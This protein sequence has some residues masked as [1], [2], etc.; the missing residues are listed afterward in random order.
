MAEKQLYVALEIADHEIRL[1]VGEFFNTRFNILKIE[2]V[3]TTGILGQ[4]IVKKEAVIENIKKAVANASKQIGASIE[5]VLLCIPSVNSQRI[6]KRVSVE[7]DKRVSVNDISRAV[8]TASQIRPK[9]GL[10]LIN[11]A[12][13]KY[14]CNGITT[15]RMPLNEECDELIVDVDLL[16]ADRTVTFDYVSCVEKA[17]LSILDICLDSYAIAKEA[18]LFEQAL[19][20][21]TILV[22][23]QE[24]STTLSYFADGRLASSI[25][26]NTGL[27]DFI[28]SLLEKTA[29]KREEA[30]KL[31]KYNTRL[32]LTNFETTPVYIWAAGGKTKTLSEKELYETIFPKAKEWVEEIGSLCGPILERD[33]VK[34]VLCGDGGE[35]QGIDALMKEILHMDV[36]IYYPETVGGRDSSL[37]T[38]LGAFYAYKDQ[39]TILSSNLSSIN[40]QEFE[41][42]INIKRPEK[43]T[44]DTITKKLKG[45]LFD[46]KQ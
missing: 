31:L 13:I 27:K 38:C 32:N 33:P 40:M 11:V 22:N 20:H 19:N 18:V 44:E 8:K 2:R 23:L 4:K 6:S 35:L 29:I 36:S 15:R 17:G 10:A 14:T 21:P 34:F 16:C 39:Q 3:H 42:T 1:I 24:Q 37:V 46:K 7:V 41:N 5:R 43:R 28:A 26:M 25:V 9:D 45:M 12:C 30:M